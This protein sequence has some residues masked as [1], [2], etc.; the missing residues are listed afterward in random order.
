MPDKPLA[1]HPLR[2]QLANELH[3]RPFPELTAP[4]RAAY[5]AIKQPSNAAK[6]D[7]KADRAHL[8]ALL[9]LFGAP[10]P[11]P[12]ASHYSGALGNS[13]LKWE[14]HSEFVS[15]TLFA[16]GVADVP[17][18]GSAFLL[19]P[20]KWL[21]DAPGVV[22]SSVLI[23]METADFQKMP[24]EEINA[25][26]SP[27]FVQESMA[28]SLVVDAEAVV[29][30]DFRIDPMGNV[31]FAIIAN[32]GISP[33]RLGRIAQRLL[34]VETYKSA[35]MLAFPM[36]RQVAITLSR[37]EEDLETVFQRMNTDEAADADTLGNLLR[38]SAEIENLSAST[39]FRFGAAKAYSKIVA[40]R[41]A[42]LREKRFEGR[43]LLAEFMMRRYDPA[44]RT[45]ISTQM[46][47]RDLSTRAERA[48]NLLRTRVDV[49]T[50]QQNNQV[51]ARMDDRAALQLRLQET[52][53]GL[54]VVAISYYA[55][56]LLGYFLTPLAAPLGL[57]KYH[58]IAAVTLPVV[59][60]VWWLAK[61]V[62][63]KLK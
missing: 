42:V 17:F 25:K 41:I 50:A 21:A 8:I 48:A 62:R 4:C 45:C 2:Y 57:Q 22:L 52:V 19:F 58:I 23:R 24:P 11:A 30:S 56:S 39:A 63:K 55:V 10:H 31:R 9:D 26:I 1:D 51:L 54:S 7:R 27:W 5:L 35:S 43:Q 13:H 14:M 46:R 59:L 29:A 34:E 38:L 36:S 16:N 12:D 20:K 47:L 18:D 44:M 61:R 32:A 40:Q 6:R 33:R 49:L 28:A 60:L 37:L 3:A 53:E 15:Y